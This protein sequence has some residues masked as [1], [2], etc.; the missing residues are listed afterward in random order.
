MEW[1]FVPNTERNSIQSVH[2]LNELVKLLIRFDLM[3]FHCIPPKFSFKLK[4]RQL[5]Q[6]PSLFGIYLDNFMPPNKMQLHTTLR[7]L[8][9][10][11]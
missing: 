6:L 8:F 10:Q 9:L 11:C 5:N 3:S 4:M 1:F 2:V 7:K